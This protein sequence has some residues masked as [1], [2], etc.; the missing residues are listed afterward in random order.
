MLTFAEE[1]LLLTLDDETGS[2]HIPSTANFRLALAGSIL[3]DLAFMD[4]I[5]TDLKKLVVVDGT[6][7]GTP[8]F[9]KALAMLK[10]SPHPRSTAHWVD[11]ISQG[12]SGLRELFIG[13]LVKKGVLE[14]REQKKLGIFK[15]QR[16]F[17]TESG[18]KKEIRDRIR[19][20]VLDG[21][22]PDPRDI[23]LITLVKSSDLIGH[24]F[25]KEERETAER[26]VYQLSQMDLIGQAVTKAIIRDIISPGAHM[27]Y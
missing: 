6:S 21:D 25:T 7:T 3:M 1:L 2:F 23:V 17:T 9:D 16:Y 18:V 10:E 19:H 20:L 22:I 27:S 24:I 15:K 4:R 11:T 26:R 14:K 12:F 8:I 5:D 13:S